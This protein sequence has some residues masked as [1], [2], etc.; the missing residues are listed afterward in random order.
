[1]WFPT[2]ILKALLQPDAWAEGLSLGDTN[3]RPREL[4]ESQLALVSQLERS[5][6]AGGPR[7]DSQI[8]VCE[9]QAAAH[10]R[11]SVADGNGCVCCSS[12]ARPCSPWQCGCLL[13][14][15]Q[16]QKKPT[17]TEEKKA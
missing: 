15:S 4:P 8:E 7:E 14:L 2:C 13:R 6:L 11:S 16:Q 10:L 5:R 9:L 12:P 1:M 3:K 17:P